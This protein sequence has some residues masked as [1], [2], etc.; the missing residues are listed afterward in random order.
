MDG[1]ST[2]KMLK[3]YWEINPLFGKHP[4]KDRVFLEGSALIAAEIAAAFAVSH[5][6]FKAGEI[7]GLFLLIQSGIHI[8]FAVHNYSL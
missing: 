6:N 5:F 4:S 1:L 3:T 8:Y 2:V 7:F